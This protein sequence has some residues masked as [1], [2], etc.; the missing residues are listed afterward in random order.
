MKRMLVLADLHCGH[1]CGL[2][3]PS[4]QTA[5]PTT[6]GRTKRAKFADLQKEAW[7]W[8]VRETSKYRPYDMIFVNGDAIDGRGERSG[9]TELVTV[10][11]EEQANMALVAIQKNM[12]GRKTK[13]ALTYGTAYH[14]GSSED[15]ENRI[16]EDLNAVKI[17]AH[18]WVNLDG[19]IFDFKHHIAGSQIPHGRHTATAREAL[20]S[21]LWAEQGLS[22]SSDVLIR[23][24]VHYHQYCGGGFS[25]MLRMT[26]P[27]LQTMGGK[28][29][30][31]RCSGLIDYGFL[32][33][34]ASKKEYVWW[35][36]L[37]EL[38]GQKSSAIKA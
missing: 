17:G 30:A 20:W 26:T 4:W 11:R 22:P 8:F 29:G 38:R 13:V 6:K 5:P 35:A 16:A 36:R 27:G 15:W 7:A 33:F 19:V 3:P 9:S 23:S 25:E 1:V 31:R 2:T 28:Y 32:V 34:E 37:A 12:N 24:H 14:T 18:E 10:D 21:A